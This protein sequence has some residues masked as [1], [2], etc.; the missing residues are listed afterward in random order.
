MDAAKS[1]SVPHTREYGMDFSKTVQTENSSFQSDMW[2]YDDGKEPIN[3]L[4]QFALLN[5]AIAHF[6]LMSVL[7]LPH[8][9][10]VLTCQILVPLVLTKVLRNKERASLRRLD[11]IFYEEPID[12]INRF[13]QAS[14]IASFCGYEASIYHIWELLVLHYHKITTKYW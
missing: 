5:S 8:I 9:C 2:I 11:F 3:V 12:A 1:N 6:D 14:E 10:K 4:Y 7:V 13:I